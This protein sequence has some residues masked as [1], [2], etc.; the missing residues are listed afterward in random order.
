MTTIHQAPHRGA[1][2]LAATP[3]SPLRIALAAALSLSLAGCGILGGGA[4]SRQSATIYAPLVQVAPDPSWPAVDWQLAIASATAARM[5]DSP[6]ISVRP[7]PSELQVYAGASWSQPATSLLEGALLRTFEDSGRIGAVG[8]S[9]IGL[10]PD[11][12]LVLDVRRFEADYAGR[13]V[14]SA[15][16]EVAAKLLYNRDQRVVAAHTFHRAEQAAGTEVPQ[17]V[18]A[19]E[20]ALETITAEIVG[21]TLGSGQADADSAPPA[22]LAPPR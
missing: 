22:P 10:R 12:K 18:S 2:G 1:H 19:F 14:P 3:R 8:R 9:E 11:Y 21:W 4:G 7:T 6:R 13:A 15:T 5:I 17:V 20:R 16:I